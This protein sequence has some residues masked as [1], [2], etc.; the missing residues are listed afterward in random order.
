MRQ[1]NESSEMS[2]SQDQISVLK[3][4]LWQKTALYLQA[5][6]LSEIWATIADPFWRCRMHMLDQ[7][8]AALEI[9]PDAHFRMAA[10]L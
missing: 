8:W 7:I 2:I 4:D 9:V 1:K 3:A 10:G 5:N 6:Q